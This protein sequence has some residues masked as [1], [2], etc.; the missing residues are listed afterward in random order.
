MV[1]IGDANLPK[2]GT[3]VSTSF[4]DYEIESYET[5]ADGK[6]KDV[7]MKDATG[8]EQKFIVDSKGIV[9]I[10]G[11]NGQT[12]RFSLDPDS[13]DIPKPKGAENVLRLTANEWFNVSF[14]AVFTTVMA[15]LASTLS[16]IRFEEG[17]E[18][19]K[20]RVM[21]AAIAFGKAELIKE[22][23]HLEAQKEIAQAV[24]SFVTAGMSAVTLVMTAMAMNN[25]KND[26]NVKAAENKMKGMID[27]NVK[28]PPP[29]VAVFQNQASTDSKMGNFKDF[30]K[31]P[32]D[33]KYANIVKSEAYK[34][35]KAA[36]ANYNQKL[37]TQEQTEQS[38]VRSVE[39]VIRGLAEGSGAAARATFTEAKGGVDALIQMFELYGKVLQD[40]ANTSQKARDDLSAA[41]NECIRALKETVS[42]DYSMGRN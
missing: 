8:V 35:Y 18:V 17:L 27:E 21:E 30:M 7:I 24:T 36:E 11:P 38:K 14:M 1:E 10:K 42:K 28:P 22:A 34:D 25:A 33:P 40:F 19:I 29:L 41:F 15:E 12:F 13:P 32:D 16:K 9:E 5:G 6:I 26:P 39:Q 31:N 20:A 23:A 4:G 3:T 2:I 37:H